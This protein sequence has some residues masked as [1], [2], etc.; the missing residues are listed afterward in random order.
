MIVKFDSGSRDPGPLVET[1]ILNTDECGV[2]GVGATLGGNLFYREAWR[3]KGTSA[4][5]KEVRFLQSTTHRNRQPNSACEADFDIYL[6]DGR[7]IEVNTCARRIIEA[8]I[9]LAPKKDVRAPFRRMR[10][11]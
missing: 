8:A 6:E 4:G 7:V 1:R 11:R 9:K 5:I 2:A 10:G 3:L